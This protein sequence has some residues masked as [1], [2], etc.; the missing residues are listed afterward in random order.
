MPK[1]TNQTTLGELNLEKLGIKEDDK[2][3]RKFLMLIEGTYGVGVQKSL[4]K[5]GYTEQRYYQL[6]KAFRED[7][8]QALLEEK[9]GPKSKRVRT[10]QVERQIIRLRFLDPQSSA[11]VIAQK[12]TQQGVKI[13]QRSV[14]RTIQEYGLQKKTLSVI[15]AGE[16]AGSGIPDSAN[17][18]QKRNP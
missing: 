9:R 17:Q 4:E 18:T 12:L 10:E 5:Y 13:S 1:S 2:A 14:E 15:P 8:F 7:G 6:K 3:S 16:P 11:A